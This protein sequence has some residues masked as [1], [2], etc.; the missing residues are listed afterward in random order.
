MSLL[1]LRLI[2]IKARFGLARRRLAE[3]ISTKANAALAEVVNSVRILLW[4]IRAAPP[5]R[6]DC[7]SEGKSLFPEQMV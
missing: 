7:E 5:Q 4:F 3:P 1:Y 2:E 6:G